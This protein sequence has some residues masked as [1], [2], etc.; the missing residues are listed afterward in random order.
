MSVR[1]SQEKMMRLVYPTSIDG[2]LHT[3]F[4]GQVWQVVGQNDAKVIYWRK[5]QRGK[6]SGP[7][8]AGGDLERA[9]RRLMEA[10]C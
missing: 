7:I 4:W 1:K 8:F 5:I 9:A 3:D 10:G 6:L 2:S